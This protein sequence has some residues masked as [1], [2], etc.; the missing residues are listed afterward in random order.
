MKRIRN[1]IIL[2]SAVLVLIMN[3]QKADIRRPGTFVIPPENLEY[4]KLKYLS[5]ERDIQIAI[6]SLLADCE[7]AFKKGTFSVMNKSVIPPSGDKHDYYSFGPYWWPDPT[8][9]DGLPYIRRDGE[10]NP[11]TRSAKFDRQAMRLFI[12]SVF[13][14]SLAYYFTGEERY[15]QF[16]AELLRTWFIDP[17]TKMNPHLNFAQ[18]I[19]GRVEGR[20]IG[21]IETVEFIYIV[22]AIGMIESSTHFTAADKDALVSWF[23]SYLHWM[24]TSENGIEE[25][26]WYNNHGTWYDVQKVSFSL[27]TG[28]DSLARA[29]CENSKMRRIASQIEPDGTMPHELKRTRSMHYSLY[30]LT[31][32]FKLAIMAERLSIDLWH[33]QAPEGQSIHK[34]LGFLMPYFYK[35]DAWPYKQI[36]PIEETYDELDKILRI[37]DT[38]YQDDHYKKLYHDL[39]LMDQSSV[40]N[41]IY[42]FRE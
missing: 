39:D 13:P 2:I 34:A 36:K 4:T 16:A 33:Y 12:R 18:A 11:E 35:P 32:F 40:L 31:A 14:L 19:P 17:A 8:Q 10:R 21:I 28:K 3:C 15:A 1:V 37:A 29:T 42:P 25:D 22:D 26:N 38:K 41:L 9:P 6:D 23:D 24:M 5:A 20:G 30:N 7:Q 27:F